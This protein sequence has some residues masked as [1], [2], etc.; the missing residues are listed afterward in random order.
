MLDLSLEDFFQV[1]K[2]KRTKGNAFNLVVPKWNIKS[3]GRPIAY[4]HHFLT[5]SIIKH[6]NRLKGTSRVVRWFAPSLIVPNLHLVVFALIWS[7]PS[8]K[9]NKNKFSTVVDLAPPYPI[10]A[11]W[12]SCFNFGA[13]YVRALRNRQLWREASENEPERGPFREKLCY[14]IGVDERYGERM[15]WL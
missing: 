9:M 14:I 8:N 15:N 4:R 2:Y 11:L 5:W 1:N 7:F 10:R 12:Y 6:W 3:T 13:W